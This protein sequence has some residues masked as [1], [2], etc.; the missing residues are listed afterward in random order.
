[1]ITYTTKNYKNDPFFEIEFHRN[2]V[3]R[4]KE[5]NMKKYIW[6]KSV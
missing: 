4:K 3:D 5:K 1:M 2:E 6:E